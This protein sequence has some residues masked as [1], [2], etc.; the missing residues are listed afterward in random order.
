MREAGV[1]LI[2]SILSRIRA[3]AVEACAP[4]IPEKRDHLF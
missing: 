3:Q 2:Y 1:S 4:A